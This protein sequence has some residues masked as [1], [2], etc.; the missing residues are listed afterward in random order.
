MGKTQNLVKPGAVSSYWKH[1]WPARCTDNGQGRGILNPS[2]ADGQHHARV[3]WDPGSQKNLL[4]LFLK[5]NYANIVYSSFKVSFSSIYLL[6]YTEV[7]VANIR[8]SHNRNNAVVVLMLTKHFRTTLNV[9]NT[10]ARYHF[11]SI[12]YC[13]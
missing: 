8:E 2:P 6:A 5:R 10:A 7:P 3:I 13:K 1:S 12:I 11:M 9:R 4:Q